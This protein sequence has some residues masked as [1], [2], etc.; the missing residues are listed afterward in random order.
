VN[1]QTDTPA[2]RTLVERAESILP[3]LIQEVIRICE[4]P[5]PTFAEERRSQYVQERMSALGLADVTVDAVG[6][7][8]GRIRGTG[9]GPTVLLAAHID[10][11]FPIDTNVR[12]RVDGEILRAPSVGDNS[13]CVATMLYTAKIL[14]E[15]RISLPGDVIFTATV[16][17]EGLGNLRGIRAIMERYRSE[18]DYVLPLDGSLGSMVRQGV[19]SRRFRLAVA[20]EGGHSWGAFGAPSAIHSLGRM[21]AQISDIRVPANPKTTFNVGTISGGTSVNTIAARAEAVIDLRSLDPDELRKLEERVRRIVSEIARQAGVEATLELLGDRPVGMI[22]EEHPLCTMVR[23]V[24]YQLGIQTRSYPSSTDGNVPLAMGIPA[25]TVGVTL[26][27]NGHRLDEYIHTTP[28]A[29]GLAQVLLL[30]M[31]A[32]H[33]PVRAR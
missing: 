7:V 29:R 16:G 1:P 27:G 24:H 4:I 25:V 12:V 13:A 10:T 6:N 31:A 32:Q 20:G 3:E 33:L 2:A 19:G 9:S 15:D 30:L 17:E 22:P 8:S 18:V 23:R 26:G 28:L 5:A 11:V 21:I 14:L